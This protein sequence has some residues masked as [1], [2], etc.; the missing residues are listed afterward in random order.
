MINYP[1]QMKKKPTT[2][3]VKKRNLKKANLGT[4]FES[5]LN[6]SNKYYLKNNIASIVF[7]FCFCIVPRRNIF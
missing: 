4:D 7:L 1:N 6:E 2:L 5:K 3:E